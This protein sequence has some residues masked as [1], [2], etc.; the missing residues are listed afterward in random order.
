MDSPTELSIENDL[1]QKR[2]SREERSNSV[3]ILRPDGSSE[4][5]IINNNTE[6][7]EEVTKDNRTGLMAFL[8]KAGLAELTT[9]TLPV[10]INEPLSFLMRITEQ[11]QY[12]E[13]LDQAAICEDSLQR[14]LY[15][16]CFAISCYSCTERSGKPFN[17]LLGETYECY[18]PSRL[19]FIA[20]QVSHHPPISAAHA[21]NDNFVFWQHKL[22]KSKFGGNSLEFAPPGHNVVQLKKTKEV[23]KWEDVKLCVHNVIVGTIWLEHFGDMIIQNTTNGEKAKLEFKKCGWFSKGWHEVE[24][25]IYDAKGNGCIQIFGKWNDTVHGKAT[26]YYNVSDPVEKESTTPQLNR[27]GSSTQLS[28]ENTAQILVDKKAKKQAKKVA[29]R[30][31]K[32]A[33]K[34]RN[35]AKKDAKKACEERKKFEKEFKKQVRKKLTNDESL[36]THTIKPLPADKISCKYMTD[37]TK[38]TMELMEITDFLRETLP[39]TDSRLRMDRYYLEKSD[40]KQ[41]ANE[42]SRLEEKQRAEKKIREDRKE[43]WRPKYFQK[44]IDK[45]G[46][47]YW[48]FLDNYWQER[49]ERVKKYNQAHNIQEDEEDDDDDDDDDDST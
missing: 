19:R 12:I 24:G 44:A 37:F 16:T 4:E 8:A 14:L 39:P 29:K 43:E 30:E 11:L 42:K 6:D 2:V 40:T 20:E 47:E 3:E 28:K 5:K 9:I 33:K 27:D 15:V 7:M 10:T 26:K 23:F 46:V 32:E 41:A 49:A 45:D 31:S 18:D 35:Q 22:V 36:W 21:E 25:T 17:P 34:I 13:L 38:H 1:N 48:E